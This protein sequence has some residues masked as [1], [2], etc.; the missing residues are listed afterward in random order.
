M[1][2]KDQIYIACKAGEID[3]AEALAQL[4]VICGCCENNYW[5]CERCQR[6][7]D[8]CRCQFWEEHLLI[9]SPK[10]K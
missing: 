4:S 10:W 6:C 8:C 7:P 9:Q 1:K 2:R 5:V 3:W